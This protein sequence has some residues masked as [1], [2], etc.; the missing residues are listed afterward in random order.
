MVK[1]LISGKKFNNYK[2]I[3]KDIDSLIG[4]S[5]NEGKKRYNQK[6]GVG[7]SKYVISYHDGKKKH[8]DGSDF[9]DIQIFRNKKDLAK[10]VKHFT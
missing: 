2:D 1:N 3:H 7:K 8:K 4:E 6:D 10:F 9:F 5:V